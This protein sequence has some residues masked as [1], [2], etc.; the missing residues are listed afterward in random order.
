MDAK[1]LLSNEEKRTLSMIVQVGEAAYRDLAQHPLFNHRYF[2]DIKG[3]LRTKIVQIQCEMESHEENF[4][5]EFYQRDFSYSLCVPELRTK[6]LILHLAR[7]QS[8]ESLPYKA[9][10]KVE[11]SNNN[12]E[13][14]SQ[15]RINTLNDPPTEDEP[16]YGLVAFGGKNKLEF[17]RVQL[18]AP[19]YI[20]IADYIDIPILTAVQNQEDKEVFER[21]KAGLKR[22]F[23]LRENLGEIIS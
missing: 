17:I 18:P 22:E 14:Y 16:Y 20:E 3:R 15:L 6:D 2:Q 13:M 10:Y 4:P 12:S 19:G 5:F 9:K 23:L 7:S 8:A 1:T 11:L 21:K